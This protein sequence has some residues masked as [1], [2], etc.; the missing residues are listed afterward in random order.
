MSRWKSDGKAPDDAWSPTQKLTRGHLKVIF[1]SGMG[2]FTDAYDLFIIGIVV[3][4]FLAEMWHLNEVQVG[5]LNSI[6]IVTAVVGQLL[7]GRLSDMLGRKAVYGVEAM[8]LSIGA[9]A[10]ALVSSFPALLATRALVGLGIGGDYP[11]SATIASEYAPTAKR[12]RAV[13]LVF[14]SQGFGVITA[15]IVGVL[16]AYYL[17]PGLAW[18]VMLGIGAIPPALV[19]YFRRK[20]PETPRYSALVK[21]DERELERSFYVAYGRAPTHDLRRYRASS[22]SYREF[23]KAFS[24]I[25]VGTALS[26]LLMD[27]AFYGT[28]IYSSAITPLIVGSSKAV[29]VDVMRSGLPYLVGV[30]GYF[31]AAAL[32]D[33]LG[34]KTLQI[35]GFVAMAAIYLALL[36]SIVQVGKSYVLLVPGAF[37]LALFGLSF[38]FINLGPNTTTFIV[39]AEV[40]PVRFRSTGH[41]ISAAAGKTGAAIATFLMP[42]LLATWGLHGVF[43]LLALVS[44]AGAAVTAAFV[45][46]A[47]NKTLEE[48]S[49]ERIVVAVQSSPHTRS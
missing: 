10:S 43:M 33:R 27:M 6:A 14:S 25:L 31:I 48:A 26:W 16:A 18:R 9:A 13:A 23:F 46:E 45:P 8:L 7:F 12:G 11:T 2:F 44:I 20:V 36:F 1:V 21:G 39:P 34:R 3:N 47:R 49:R 35:G 28:G 29:W 38:T 30:P 37:A 19:I 5:L 42:L 24:L 15:V 32:V 22:Y 4:L 40:Y 41:G 17:P